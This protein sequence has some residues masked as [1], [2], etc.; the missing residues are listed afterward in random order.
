M[1][2]R[3]VKPLDAGRIAEIYNYYIENTIITFETEKITAAE[4]KKRIASHRDG[5]FIV[6]EVEGRII[7][8]AY[9][10]QFQERAAY[11]YTRELSIYLDSEWTGKGYGMILYEA[12]FDRL[13]KSKYK[14]LV[15]GIAL[16]NDAS[17]KLHRKYG[18]KKVANFE[19]VGYKFG[20]WIDV[21]YWEL[22]I[23]KLQ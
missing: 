10:D 1:K 13:K 16:P 19:K 20:K 12:L 11:E 6:G 21:G 17:V 15:G 22:I 9:A 8:Y 2:I 14:V 23:K 5:L 7:G 3:S 18:F 4:M